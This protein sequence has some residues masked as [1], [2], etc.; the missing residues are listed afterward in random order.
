[1]PRDYK[2]QIEFGS[3]VITTRSKLFKLQ[4]D[5]DI[6]SYLHRKVVFSNNFLDWLQLRQL[7]MLWRKK[8]VN[9][10]EVFKILEDL[11]RDGVIV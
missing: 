11:K 10:H 5:D 4:N 6:A 8:N 3:E 9:N 1:M 2:A 7:I